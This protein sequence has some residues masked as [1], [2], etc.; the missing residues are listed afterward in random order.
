MPTPPR[1]KRASPQFSV[2]DVVST[3]RWFERVLG[4]EIVGTFGEPPVFAMVG[5][6]EVETYF[7]QLPPGPATPRVRAPIAY[8]AYYHVDGVNALAAEL[9]GRGAEIVEGPVDRVYGMR[10]VVV[11]DPNGLVLAFGEERD[12]AST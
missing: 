3:A 2:P 10:E 6:D 8:D 7:S 12:E 4:F 9:R 5:R 1:I 11:R